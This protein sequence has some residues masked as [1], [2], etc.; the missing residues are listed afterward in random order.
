MKAEQMLRIASK[1]LRS[2]GIDDA[3]FDAVCLVEHVTGLDRTRIMLCD[4]DVTDEQAA[5]LEAAVLRRAGGEPL[6]YIIGEWDFFGRTF[7][8]GT[9]VLI[10]RPET[11]LLVELALRKLEGC[12]HPVVFD[13]CAGSGCIGL[14][15]ASERPDAHVYLFEKY[16]EA[17]SYLK[18]NIK[19]LELTNSEAVRYDIINGYDAKRFD[20]PDL[21]VSNPPYIRKDELGSLQPEV[22]REPVTALDGGDDGAD[23]YRVIARSWLPFVRSKGGVIVECDPAQ[24]LAVAGMFMPRAVKVE[25]VTDTFGLQR[26]VAADI[27]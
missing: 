4:D 9:G 23:F 1:K 12:R 26:A 11:E 21:I 19:R 18:K 7:E 14:S 15:I 25:I 27:S 5:L 3:Y 24:A 22:K 10:P 6:Q 20:E 16:D 2:A 8:V 17:Y 13:L